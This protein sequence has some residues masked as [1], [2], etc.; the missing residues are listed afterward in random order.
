M[1]SIWIELLFDEAQHNIHNTTVV[2]HDNH[3]NYSSHCGEASKLYK[4]LENTRS[5]CVPSMIEFTL[6]VVECVIHWFTRCKSRTNNNVTT[7]RDASIAEPGETGIT[8]ELLGEDNAVGTDNEEE[9]ANN[10]RNQ[11]GLNIPGMPQ[12]HRRTCC[13][14]GSQMCQVCLRFSYD[15]DTCYRKF[16]RYCSS[17]LYILSYPF[18]I[19][20]SV[21]FVCLAKHASYYPKPIDNFRI[22]F[23][24]YSIFWYAV[25]IGFTFSAIAVAIYF[26]P[27]HGVFK[28]LNGLE[29]LL[30]LALL[31]P[32]LM[33]SFALIAIFHEFSSQRPAYNDFNDPWVFVIRELFNTFQILIQI[34]L[35]FL[36]KRI[37]TQPVNMAS[38]SDEALEASLV[39]LTG[40]YAYC[41]NCIWR[42]VLL[43]SIFHLAA[44]NAA[45]WYADSFVDPQ[46]KKMSFN[47]SFFDQTYW[48]VVSGVFAP[49]QIFYRFHS[50]LLLFGA[51]RGLA[52]PNKDLNLATR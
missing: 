41:S 6:L 28:G 13:G 17:S 24:F 46:E 45:Y 23:C 48:P 49:L 12:R 14:F 36:A 32:I 21:C 19:A 51:W 26:K 43:A 20:L 8:E 44:T 3:S 37:T 47:S 40:H 1:F 33:H 5:A 16:C 52:F 39:S 2:D 38:T 35:I 50:M 31:G 42:F 9:P 22:F 34:P 25:N 7:R 29:H 10:H 11:V 18:S 15:N 4:D 27:K 30:L